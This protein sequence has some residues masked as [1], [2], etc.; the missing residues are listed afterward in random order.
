MAITDR[1]GVTVSAVDPPIAGDPNPGL[2]IKAPCL[3]ATTANIVLAGV[4]TIDGVVVGNS[5]ERVLVWKQTD[6]TTN[7]LYNASSGNWTRTIDAATNDQWASGLQLV[8]SGGATLSGSQFQVTTSD[9]ITLGTS[10]IVFI[11]GAVSASRLI[12]TTAPLQGGGNLASN[13]T[14]SLST[15]SSL[16]VTAAS[17][18]AVAAFAG[19]THNFITAFNAAGIPQ[20]AQPQ[21]GDIG[22]AAALTAS[23]STN[24]TLT[25]SGAPTSALLA[26][27]NL[28]VAWTGVLAAASGGTG[29]SSPTAHSLLQAEGAGNFGLITAATSGNVVIDQGPG[30]DWASRTISGDATLSASGALTI[31]AGAVTNAKTANVGAATLKGNPTSATAVPQDF[32]IQGLVNSTPNATLDFFPFY[33]HA[34]STI[35]AATPSQIATAIGAGVASI[36]GQSGALLLPFSPGG[37]LTTTSGLA[38]MTSDVSAATALYYAPSISGYIPIYDGANVATHQF[39]SSVTDTV[40]LTLTLGSN[41]AASTLFDVFVTL[42]TGTVTL[43]TGP[44]W[45]S[46]TAGSSSRGYSLALYGGVQTNAASMTVRDTNS[47]TFAMGANQGTYVGTILTNGSTGQ[48]DFKFGGLG[49]GGSAAVAGIWNMYNRALGAFNVFDSVATCGTSATNTFQPFDVGG[50]GSGLNNRVTFVTGMADDPV[51]GSMTSS[52]NWIVGSQTAFVGVALNATNAIWAKCSAGWATGA[53]PARGSLV[54]T[55]KG[56]ATI[57]LNYLQAIFWCDSTSVP[58]ST[59]GGSPSAQGLNVS[60][61][62]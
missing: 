3:V 22:G 11:S 47:H 46:S 31:A 45:A 40:G 28:L 42:L 25:L 8:V 6:Q 51:E 37:R 15:N 29:L 17:A 34:T 36:N 59:N 55:A 61:W 4:Q 44:A 26:G 20:T 1:R 19:S 16:Q 12:N 50:T 30:A 38:V 62:W 60:W 48:I 49:S 32:T 43:V 57:G 53:S 18:L 23:S 54:G 14:L 13:R 2:A 27:V 10:V 41:W 24:V 39:T 7:G 33:N 21:V 58:F 35:Q 52:V 9:P 56:Y 5:N